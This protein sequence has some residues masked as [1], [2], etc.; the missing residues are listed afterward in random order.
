[1]SGCNSQRT[2]A[3]YVNVCPVEEPYQYVLFE[4]CNSDEIWWVVPEGEQYE[5]LLEL[6]K[7]NSIDW[8]MQPAFARLRGS[9]SAS[10]EYGPEGRQAREFRLREVLEVRPLAEA[11]CP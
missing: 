6:Y 8:C 11:S 7:Q 4:V 9:L 3:G 2:Y 1:M 5:E 10:G